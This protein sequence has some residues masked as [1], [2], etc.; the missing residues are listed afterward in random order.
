MNN[1]NKKLRCGICDKVS[2]GDIQN[3]IG[4]YSDKPF[5]EDPK[6]KLHFICHECRG[7]I[8]LALEDYEL[9]EIHVFNK[10][11]IPSGKG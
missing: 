6:S 10:I 7:E 8:D 4:D 5:H 9:D 3:N 1:N 2:S 11:L